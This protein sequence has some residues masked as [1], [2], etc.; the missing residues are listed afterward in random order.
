MRVGLFTSTYLPTTGGVQFF[1]YWLL[2][3][4]DEKI[5][6]GS[7]EQLLFIVPRSGDKRFVDFQNIQVIEYEYP[8]DSRKGI[9]R[10]IPQLAKISRDNSLDIL[11]CHAALPDGLCC[12]G[13]KGLTG[14]PFMVTCHGGDIAV[15]EEFGY[16]NRLKR[17][18]R[19]LTRLV[20]KYAVA[21]TTLSTDMMSFAEE[22]GA[23]LDRMFLIPG[24][25][26]SSKE[27]V[28]AAVN[29][30]TNEIKERYSIEEKHTVYLT[31]SGMRKIKGHEP[32]VRA[33]AKALNV[34][35][36]LFL[37]VGANGHETE[38]IK[39]LVKDLDIGGNVKFI[40]FIH[41]DEKKAWFN[42]ADVYCNTAFFEPFGIVYLEAVLYGMAVLGS[43]RGGAKDIFEH[44]KEAHLIDPVDLESITDG[45]LELSKKERREKL[46][47]NARSILP[48]YEIDKIAD[49][50][51]AYYKKCTKK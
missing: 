3:A 50:Y 41:D 29:R 31:L 35:K 14:I 22:A 21:V 17:L 38:R 32:L 28:N 8:F 42:V 19:F 44:K 10:F 34:K 33:F 1:L 40:G 49:E 4:I 9:L 36:D 30:K 27:I 5:S 43:I 48:R 26:D 51:I 20:L 18:P 37:F 45:I 24:G 47:E 11:H 12:A 25:I 7:M 39:A 6:G 46:T 2:K 23:S 16:G 13:A 15:S